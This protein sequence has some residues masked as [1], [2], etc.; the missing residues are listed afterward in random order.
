MD[1]AQGIIVHPFR[2]EISNEMRHSI[3]EN[4]YIRFRKKV[5]MDVEKQT[6]YIQ[7]LCIFSQVGDFKDTLEGWDCLMPMRGH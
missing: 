4:K 3:W 1:G 6:L 7:E 2:Q 5:D